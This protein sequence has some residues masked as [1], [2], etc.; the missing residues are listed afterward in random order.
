MQIHYYSEVTGEYRGTTDARLDP[1]EGTPLIPRLA[2][3]VP[4]PEERPGYARCWI[5]GTWQQVEDHRGEVLFST[6]SGER[7]EWGELGPIPLAPEGWTPEAPGDAPG[8]HQ[9]W[10]AEA[11]T[12]KDDPEAM[13]AARR[14]ALLAELAGLDLFLPRAVEDCIESGA[15]QASALSTHNQERLARKHSLRAEL[16]ELAG[17]AREEA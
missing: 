15:L 17:L 13:A 11:G 8:E 12:W 5:D 3:D 1:L 2:T 9:I 14:A 7:R 16:A 6:S 10:D 4:P